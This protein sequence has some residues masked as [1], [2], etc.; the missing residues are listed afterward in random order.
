MSLKE[1]RKTSVSKN[2]LSLIPSALRA[3]IDRQYFSVKLQYPKTGIQDGPNMFEH[4]D[5]CVEV[6]SVWS[7]KP[8]MQH[9]PTWSILNRQRLWMNNDW[10]FILSLPL[11]LLMS[12]N[13]HVTF[14]GLKLVGHR[15]N[16]L[17]FPTIFILF[18][19]YTRVRWKHRPV[20]WQLCWFSRDWAVILF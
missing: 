5:P 2:F 4:I 16:L 19:T 9:E 12:L 17:L 8:L 6:C 20:S 13:G 3:L 1:Q 14:D 7:V 10:R 15:F 11:Q 18:A